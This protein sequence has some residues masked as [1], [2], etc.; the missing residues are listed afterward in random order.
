MVTTETPLKVKVNAELRQRRRRSLVLMTSSYGAR[1]STV[2]SR[3]A[4]LFCRMI[5]TRRQ[6][7]SS[8]FSMSTYIDIIVLPSVVLSDLN[9]YIKR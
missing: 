8:V 3:R 7:Y 1:V 4:S 9:R 2:Y 5:Y 6:F